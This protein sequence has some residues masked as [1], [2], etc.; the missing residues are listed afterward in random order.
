MRKLV[1]AGVTGALLVSGG[2][3]ALAQGTWPSVTV[4]PKVSPTKAGTKQH[5]RGVK[6]TT[7]FHWQTLGAASQPIVTTFRILFP[8]GSLYNGGS[9]PT[10]SQHTLSL[11]GPSGCKKAA[12]MGHGTGTAY[13]DTTVTHPTITVVNGGASK[14][15]FYTVLNNPARVQQPVVGHITRMSGKYAYALSVTIPQ[16]LRIVAGVPI[17]LTYLKVVAGGAGH[18]AWLATTGC[19]HGHWPFSV[20]TG[21]ENP[22]SNA[23]GSSSYSSSVA[24]H[25]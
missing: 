22:N 19:S 24:C 4:T 7:V 17:E 12:I 13:A 3:V 6:L 11:D 21:Y 15:Y 20:T 23:T 18:G 16:D 1:V 10:C 5:P 8:K 9:Y 14:L 2:A 25:N